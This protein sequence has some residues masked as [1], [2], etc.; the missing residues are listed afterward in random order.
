MAAVRGLFSS[1]VCFETWDERFWL[2]QKCAET[3]GAANGLKEVECQKKGR[4]LVVYFADVGGGGEEELEQE[5]SRPRV[6]AT[7]GCRK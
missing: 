2:M 4:G 3:F 7:G 1:G 6:K 5:A